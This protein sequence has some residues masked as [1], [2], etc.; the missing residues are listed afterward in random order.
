MDSTGAQ[1]KSPGST[2]DSIFVCF[3]FRGCESK[4]PNS[5]ERKPK[6]PQQQQFCGS[7][8]RSR[9]IEQQQTNKKKRK[10][11]TPENEI[12]FCRCRWSNEDSGF[13]QP[14]IWHVND[15]CPTK[16]GIIAIIQESSERDIWYYN[17]IIL[18]GGE[19]KGGVV[20]VKVKVTQDGGWGKKKE[21][22]ND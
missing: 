21:E 5:S 4:N 8:K 13:L 20:V 15:V 7:R 11:K 9:S 14:A 6:A 12:K 1:L 19:G 17:I 3:L 2:F 22:K 18:R 16:C 10:K